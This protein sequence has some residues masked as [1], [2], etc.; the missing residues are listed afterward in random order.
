MTR[1]LRV[2]VRPHGVRVLQRGRQFID[3][4]RA[5][6]VVRVAVTLADI[7]SYGSWRTCRCAGR[8]GRPL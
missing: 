6:W 1:G 7:D 8:C 3:H 2:W 4:E 5:L